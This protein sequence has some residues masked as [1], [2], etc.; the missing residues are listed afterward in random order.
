[1]SRL[2]P[3]ISTILPSVLPPVPQCFF[4]WLARLATVL[5]SWSNPVMTVTALPRLPFVSLR[6]RRIPSVGA[7]VL[8]LLQVQL[9]TGLPQSGQSLPDSVL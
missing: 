2:S 7:V 9:F 6:I 1:M 8:S 4:N 5:L 3:W